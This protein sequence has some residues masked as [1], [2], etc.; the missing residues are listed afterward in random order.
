[1]RSTATR[2]EKLNIKQ[3][4]EEDRPREKMRFKGRRALSNAELIAILIGSG[5]KKESAVGLAKRILA[6]FSNDLNELSKLNELELMKY[7]GVGEAKA[8]S[9]IAALELGRRRV[10]QDAD[11]KK[12]IQTSRAAFETVKSHFFDL[13]HEEFWVICLNRANMVSSK[14]MLSKGGVS[15]TIADVKLI[16][17]NAIEHMASS[18][19][20]CHNHPSG[21]LVASDQDKTITEKIRAAGKIMDIG[22]L[23]HLIISD[24]NYYSFADN[25]LI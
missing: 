10:D 22:L 11:P 17:K 6:D 21:N 8:I 7:N 19:I 2:L 3:W 15:G 13:R 18:I 4:S 24:N 25:G 23:D 12:K 14:F 9:I 16:F 20:V 5:N 1:M